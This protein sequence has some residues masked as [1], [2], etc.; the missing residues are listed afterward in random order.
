[1]EKL[2]NERA[3]RRLQQ[4][5]ARLALEKAMRP[6][7]G[8]SKLRIFALVMATGK[9]LRIFQHSFNVAIKLV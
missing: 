4:G 9:L 7:K 6:V 8:L 3:Q 2:R 1:L 5:T